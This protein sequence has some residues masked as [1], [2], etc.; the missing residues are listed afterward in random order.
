[1]RSSASQLSNQQLREKRAALARL[2]K[3]I[4]SQ[5][6]ATGDQAQSE[7]YSDEEHNMTVDGYEK[8][9]FVVDD[10]AEEDG[11]AGDEDGAEYDNAQ[12]NNEQQEYMHGEE[13]EE[14]VEEEEEEEPE[15]P[16]RAK[17]SK[18]S[19]FLYPLPALSNFMCYQNPV[20]PLLQGFL[21][22]AMTPIPGN[23]LLTLFKGAR[24][25]PKERRRR[26]TQ[27][28]KRM[29]QDPFRFM[30]IHVLFKFSHVCISYFDFFRFPKKSGVNVKDTRYWCHILRIICDI[31]LTLIFQQE[32]QH[33]HL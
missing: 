16:K 24:R 20:R 31:W 8:D 13:E 5:I 25:L 27:R 28:L 10:E 30:G 9:D 15:Q 4:E 11:D 19:Y 14:E 23:F 29:V 1:M 33:V 6:G 32:V 12:E 7:T 22:M 3:E 18:V 26:Q 21:T 17:T 2:M